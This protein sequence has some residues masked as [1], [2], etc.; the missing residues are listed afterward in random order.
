[1]YHKMLYLKKLKK[2]KMPKNRKFFSNF[3]IYT[4]STNPIFFLFLFF[5]L[6]IIKFFPCIEERLV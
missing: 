1:M 5:L 4:Y 6:F 3:L 2:N